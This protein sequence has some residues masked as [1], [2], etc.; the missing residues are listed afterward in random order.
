MCELFA[1]NTEYPIDAAEYL[2]DFFSHSNE[3]PNGWGLAMPSDAGC[4]IEKEPMMASKSQY[5]KSRLSG[6]IRASILLAHIRLATVGNEEYHN[7]HPFKGA[8]ISGRQ[9]T[10]M[11]NGTIFHYDGLD[12]YIHV[13]KGKTDSERVFLHLLHKI[14]EAIREKGELSF[15]QRFD[16]IEELV[17]EASPGN[18]LNL[19]I[20]DG[21]YLY[22][23][24][25]Q[26]GTLHS[27]QM[28]N[29]RLF[30]TRPL[31]K[32]TVEAKW[33]P[34]PMM[35]LLAYQEGTLVRE[36]ESHGNEYFYDPKQY[37]YL[38]LAFSEL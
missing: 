26:A 19:I 31:V 17:Y 16:V 9:W 36:G 6:N 1:L 4:S 2:R 28:E 5:L 14:N 10:F 13:Q 35:R 25:N 30:S 20:Y 7:C 27:Q 12:Q 8:D 37:E 21:E 24:T 38:F 32:S 29:G 34:L 3:H 11:H 23:H 33:K 18:K 22:V 15:E